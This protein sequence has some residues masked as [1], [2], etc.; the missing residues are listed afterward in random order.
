MDA[1]ERLKQAL[2]NSDSP[3]VGPRPFDHSQQLG[4]ALPPVRRRV[5]PGPWYQ[6]LEAGTPPSERPQP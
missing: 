4:R 6:A 5:G 1:W 3:L 2:R